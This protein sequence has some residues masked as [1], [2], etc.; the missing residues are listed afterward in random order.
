MGTFLSEKLLC[1]LCT[2]TQGYIPAK[3]YHKPAAWNSALKPKYMEKKCMGVWHGKFQKAL[4]SLLKLLGF[5]IF[6]KAGFD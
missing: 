6:L 3:K 2:S 1:L 4:Q 5:I